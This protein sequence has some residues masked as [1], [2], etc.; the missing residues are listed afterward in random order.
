MTTEVAIKTVR[1][2]RGLAQALFEELDMLR[3]GKTTPQ[4]AK[5]VT[6]YAN[7]ILAN[8]RMEMEHARFVA[9]VRGDGNQSGPS[10]PALTYAD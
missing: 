9:A 4:H 10:L 1:S 6:S 3:N 8:A 5:G 7:A 2:S